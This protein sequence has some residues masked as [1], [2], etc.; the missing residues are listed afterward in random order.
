MITAKQ[1]LEILFYR[2]KNADIGWYEYHL[3]EGTI[4]I[5]VTENSIKWILISNIDHEILIE[6][7]K[8]FC[9]KIA[10]Y[11]FQEGKQIE[12]LESKSVS[13]ETNSEKFLLMFINNEFLAHI[14]D[15]DFEI[16]LELEG[17]KNAI[18][19]QLKSIKDDYANDKLENY[20]SN[21]NI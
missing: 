11:L 13:F 9:H 3:P 1:A 6:E 18:G 17:M 21:R 19:K 10:Q 4:Y 5:H 8:K 14:K 12:A 7:I 16:K 20:G 15:S 2:S